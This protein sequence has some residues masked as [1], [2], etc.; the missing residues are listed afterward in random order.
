MECC[1]KR[2][3]ELI[4][5]PQGH[6]TC[7]PISM[8]TYQEKK[9]QMQDFCPHLQGLDLKYLSLTLIILYHEDYTYMSAPQ[10]Q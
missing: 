6:H 7:P 10:M 4:W 5:L 1:I 3:Q 2:I 8:L 9:V